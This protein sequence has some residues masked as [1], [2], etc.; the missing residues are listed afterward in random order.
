MAEFIKRHEEVFKAIETGAH[1]EHADWEH[2]EALR[3]KG[4]A[5]LLGED[6]QQMRGLVRLLCVRHRFHLAQGKIDKALKDLQTGFTMARHT[7]TSPTLIGSLI[8]I[9]MAGLLAERM[10]E[11][12]NQPGVPSLYWPL[13][14]MPTFCSSLRRPLEGE[15]LG[16]YGSFPGVVDAATNLDA[17]PIT[18]E[19]V[20]SC[21]K[22]YS[23]FQQTN[24][25]GALALAAEVRLGLAVVQKHEAAKRTLIAAG[26]PK[27]KVEAM[28]HLQSRCCIPSSSMTAHSTNC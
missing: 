25:T 6:F 1:R 19:Q 4:V 22:M 15:R 28:P 27:E 16:I 13:S 14:E 5:T 20:Q 24:L 9:A 21:V 26:R 17:G 12:L 2:L 8:E 23:Q 11:L 10:E 7:G 18:P 3:K